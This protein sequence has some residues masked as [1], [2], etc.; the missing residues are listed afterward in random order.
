VF[1]PIGLDQSTVRR[2][3][4]VTFSLIA[5]NLAVFLAVSATVRDTEEEI[6]KRGQEVMAYWALHPYLEFP[7]K[8]LPAAM[9]EA[10]RQRITMLA[11]SMRSMSGKPPASDE[12]RLK[13]QRE[14][15]DLVQKFRDALTY[16]PFRVWGL[17]PAQPRPVAF[18][19]SMFMHAGW[20]HLVGNM[21]F[22]YLSGPFVEDAYGRPLF[23]AL[24]LAS[25]VVSGLVHVAAF[26]GSDAPLVGASG[27][28]AGIMGAFLVRFVRTKIR[29][30]YFYFLFFFRSGTVDLPAWIVLPLWF[31]QQ[32]F[33]AGLSSSSGV[34]YR[35]HVGGF[36][37]GFLAAL[38]IKQLRIEERFIAP[39]IEKE[40]SV[41]QHPALEQGMELLARGDSSGAREAFRKVLASE[42]R[43]ADAHLGIWESHRQD[44]TPLEA[45]EHVVRAMDEELRRGET[46]LALAHWREMVAST[47]TGG[48]GALR[49][50]LA[51]ML[52]PQDRDGAVEVLRH[53]A[54]DT[55]AGVLAG[56]AA[57]HLTVLGAAPP[58]AP[59]PEAVAQVAY[60]HVAAPAP[61]PEPVRATPSGSRRTH[62]ESSEPPMTAGDVFGVERPADPASEEPPQ[63]FPE[64]QTEEVTVT[65]ATEPAGPVMEECALETV[66]PE[67]LM[68]RGLVGGPELV[69]Y[70]EVERI[71]VAGVTG[72]PRP[73]LILDLVLHASPGHPRTVERLV[74]SQFDPRHLIGRPDLHPLEAFRE[75]VHIIAQAS[76][77]EVSP[78]TLL[79]PSAKI[80]T[81]PSVEAYESEILR[82][83]L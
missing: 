70:V 48:P 36:A 72:S 51:T 40:I 7:T 79:V 50:R 28:I 15:D 12:Q 58:A 60:A 32:L 46:G 38:A 18:V 42:P 56:K 27:A 61:A 69:P 33:F 22:F 71:C 63:V 25:G 9:P 54:A 3:P 83:L 35:A 77:A 81:F 44:D 62:A 76:H 45:V 52:E 41:T 20:L 24:Y 65:D 66:Q 10:Q 16:H 1:I 68:L 23:A 26:P 75:L 67:G 73:Y 53:L 39:G 29:F 64:A 6:N 14:L 2:L 57:R 11:E 17:I 47:G 31:L 34:A 21:L 74:S 37:F 8:M 30:F 80:P 4:W 78:A 59:V 55:A 19:T 13:D 82:P 5:I 49:F 43:N